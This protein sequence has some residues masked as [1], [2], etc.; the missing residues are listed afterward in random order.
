MQGA[1]PSGLCRRLVAADEDVL[2]GN[3]GSAWADKGEY[4]KAIGYY[5]KALAVRERRLGKNH[6]HTQQTRTNLER[7]RTALASA[8]KGALLD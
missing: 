7:A 5:E 4:D 6:P 2:N 1:V 3:L 8:G